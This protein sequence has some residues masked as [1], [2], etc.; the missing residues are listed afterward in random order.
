MHVLG[1]IQDITERKELEAKL[2]QEARTDSL[3]GIANRR[4]FLELAGH[5]FA[6]ARRYKAKLSALMLDLDHFKEINDTYGHQV[7]DLILTKLVQVCRNAMRGED[8]IGR[9]GGEEFGILL[10]ETTREKA[11]EVAERLRHAIASAEVRV[12]Q[13]PPVRFTASVGA[14]TVRDDDPDIMALLGNADQALYAAKDA[15]RNTVR[16]A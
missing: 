15:G 5:E 9:L 14:A 10:P 16:A 4:Y 2:E 12:E 13:G 6:R 8:V 11:G 7:G 3:T 1:V